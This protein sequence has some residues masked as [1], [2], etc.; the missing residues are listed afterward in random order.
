MDRFGA[1]A[2][3]CMGGGD[4]VTTHNCTR[5]TIHQ[6]AQAA[7]IASQLQAAGVLAGEPGESGGAAG[8]QSGDVRRRPAD[9]LVCR[10]QDIRTG[11]RGTGV[12]LRSR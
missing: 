1:H 9:V 6:Q 11:K 3:T 7:N 2:E 4:K 5:D 10:A 12:E 8:E